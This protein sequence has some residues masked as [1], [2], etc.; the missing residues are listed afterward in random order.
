[1]SRIYDPKSWKK[2]QVCCIF[3]QSWHAN[4]NQRRF[5]LCVSLSP[6]CAQ[7]P[8][9]WKL[10]PGSVPFGV[11][12]CRRVLP[13]WVTLLGL[14]SSYCH[15]QRGRWHCDRHFRW[16]QY[17]CFMNF[18]GITWLFQ[19]PGVTSVQSSCG[20]VSLLAM[21]GRNICTLHQTLLSYSYHSDVIPAW[22]FITSE[23]FWV[24]LYF[25]DLL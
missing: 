21:F 14:G 19:A 13:V 7:G 16:A 8:C 15:H 18:W 10:H 24:K 4:W 2:H 23:V 22:G 6:C 5:L 17:S 9:D 25:S 3:F 20:S 11:W 1:M 12:C